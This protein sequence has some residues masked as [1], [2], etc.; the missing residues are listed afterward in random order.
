MKEVRLLLPLLLGLF[1]T[2][3]SATSLLALE[4]DTVI[5]GVAVVGPDGSICPDMAVVISAAGV[6]Q[7]VIPADQVDPALHPMVMPEGSVLTPGLHDLLGSLG[8]SGALEAGTKVWDPEL[9]PADA[10]DP[11]DP[12]LDQVAK[13]G[14][15]YTTIAAV[16]RGLANGVTAT[17][18]C[19]SDSKAH[20]LDCSKDYYAL[21][22]SALNSS[23]EPT[24]RAAMVAKWKEALFYDGQTSSHMLRRNSGILYCPEA[25]DLRQSLD[26]GWGQLPIDGKDK[27]WGR[28]PVLVHSGDARSPLHR[29]AGR[30]DALMIVGPFLEGG[31]PVAVDTAVRAAQLGVE[32]AFRGGLPAG[33][34]DHLRRSAA[35][36]LAA[37][38]DPSAARRA[39]FSNP[40]RVVDSDAI[41][42]ITPGARADLVLFS[43][44]P[45]DPAAQV[46]EIWRGGQSRRVAPPGSVSEL[47]VPR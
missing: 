28:L 24:S 26:A 34:A 10:F 31:D 1:V 43:T 42:V 12:L 22:S 46:I 9:N 45:L 44:D 8:A 41:G 27:D 30:D 11:T 32:L 15:L 16:P 36:A 2:V 38:L 25:I 6:I 37:G 20:S 18:L 47:E 33:P 13:H 7:G 19:K 21:A 14:V 3:C 4:S 39:L 23:R 17:F 35:I 29:L 40:A 5:S